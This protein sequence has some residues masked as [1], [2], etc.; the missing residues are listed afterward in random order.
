M[1]MYLNGHCHNL[2]QQKAEFST[3]VQQYFTSHFKVLRIELHF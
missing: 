2:M 1:K 3:D